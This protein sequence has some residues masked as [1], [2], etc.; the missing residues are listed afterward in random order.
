M[1]YFRFYFQIFF[2]TL[3]LQKNPLN[4]FSLK[5]TKFHCDS[6]KNESVKGQKKYW[7]RVKCFLIKISLSKEVSRRTK[8]N[9]NSS[10]M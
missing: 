1:G 2:S 7:V 3:Y 10:M 6:V 4:Y 5:V 8:K 9:G